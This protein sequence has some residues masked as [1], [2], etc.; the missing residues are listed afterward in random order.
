MGSE[1]PDVT[2]LVPPTPVGPQIADLSSEEIPRMSTGRQIGLSLFWFASSA[3]WTAILIF[4]LPQA[5][6]LIGGESAKGSTLG[7]ILPAGSLMAMFVAPF[8][9]M[10]SDRFRSRWGRRRPLMLAGAIGNVLGLLAM[11]AITPQ[12]GALVPYIAAFLFIQCF[13]NL[14]TAPYMALIPETV[15]EAQRGAASGWM[16][17]MTMLGIMA[18][19]VVAQAEPKLGLAGVYVILAGMCGTLVFMRDVSAPPM[20]SL[21][22]GDFVHGFFAPFKSQDF[23]WVFWTRFLVVLGT[24][25]VQ[26]Y[27]HYYMHDVVARGQEGFAYKLFGTT[28]TTDPLGATFFFTMAMLVGAVVSAILAGGLSDRYGRKLMVYI[29]GGLQAVVAIVILV[30][31]QFEVVVLMGVIF[32]LGYGAYQSVDWALASDVLPSKEDFAKDMGVWHVAMTLPQ[33]LGLLLAGRL[34]DHFQQAQ[35]LQGVPAPVLGFVVLFSMAFV[36]FLLGTVL[37]RQVKGAR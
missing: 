32:G 31:S 37:V 22:L 12:P 23:S 16:G 18:G 10:W 19:G 34:F 28:V 1:I 15:P 35:R 5:A 7:I 25:M 21:R 9:G 8:F 3:Q 13:N 4:L 33:V 6:L 20:P 36:F 17:L 2:A 24:Y 14:A 29:S 11:A 30:S 27:L 26:E